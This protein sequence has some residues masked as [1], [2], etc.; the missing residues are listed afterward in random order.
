MHAHIPASSVV[1]VMAIVG[2]PSPAP[3]RADIVQ[4]YVVNGVKPLKIVDKTDLLKEKLS[5]IPSE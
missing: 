2:G 5:S 4:L 3:V 1:A